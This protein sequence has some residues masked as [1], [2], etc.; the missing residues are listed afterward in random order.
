MKTENKT[1]FKEPDYKTIRELS[2]RIDCTITEADFNTSRP[3]PYRID[4]TIS[5]IH[6]YSKSKTGG[7][8]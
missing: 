5:D 1:K 4:Y 6:R 8:L 7:N 2:H 3:N